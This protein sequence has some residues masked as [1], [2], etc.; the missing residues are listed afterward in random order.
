MDFLICM[1]LDLEIKSTS[2]NPHEVLSKSIL[3]KCEDT[4]FWRVI[5][6]YESEE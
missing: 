2:L 6:D 1:K 4:E 3:E 5:E